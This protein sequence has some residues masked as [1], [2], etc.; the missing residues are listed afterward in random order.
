MRN[1]HSENLKLCTSAAVLHSN[2][3]GENF[4]VLYMAEL[5]GGSLKIITV[6]ILCNRTAIVC[7]G[8]IITVRIEKNSYQRTRF[9]RG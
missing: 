1:Y 5:F 6:R 3:H 8:E 2:S 9:K 7:E 4:E